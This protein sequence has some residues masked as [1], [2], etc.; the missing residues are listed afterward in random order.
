MTQIKQNDVGTKLI[1]NI[2]DNQNLPLNLTDSTITCTISGGDTYKK[3]T[4]SC[5][6]EDAEDGTCYCILTSTDT[7]TP[8]SY[9]V[10][11]E[12]DF[13][14]TSFTTVDKIRLKI[15]GVL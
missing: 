6:I 3:I 13:G 9:A 11:V 1:F 15:L 14:I 5:T 12:V 2:K 4:K 7:N 8:G 10:E